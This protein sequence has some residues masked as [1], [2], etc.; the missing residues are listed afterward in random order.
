MFGRFVEGVANPVVF[1]FQF[2]NSLGLA[3]HRHHLVGL[4]V[5]IAEHV[6]ADIEHQHRVAALEFAEG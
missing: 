2:L 1:G 5:E 4:N 6:A 3:F